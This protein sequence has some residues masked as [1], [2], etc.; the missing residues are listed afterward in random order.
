MAVQDHRS[1]A[2]IS[3]DDDKTAVMLIGEI[4]IATAPPFLEELVAHAEGVPDDRLVIDCSN[5]DFIDSTGLSALT[6]ARKKTGK[7]LVLLGM[8]DRCRRIFEI[9]GLDQV[10]EIV[11]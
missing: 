11:D 9:T 8:P 6:A 1:F 4:D 7:T 2:F 5:L 10:F 3:R